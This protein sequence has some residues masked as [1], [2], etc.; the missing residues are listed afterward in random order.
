M[1]M[2]PVTE[3]SDQIDSSKERAVLTQN[4]MIHHVSVARAR[5]MQTEDSQTPKLSKRDVGEN[6][7]AVKRKELGTGTDTR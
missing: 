2:I 7:N 1:I 3:Y 5:L 4:V 6:M